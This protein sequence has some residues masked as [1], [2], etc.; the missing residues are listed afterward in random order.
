GLAVRQGVKGA[1]EK[2]VAEAVKAAV[3]RGAQ[4]GLAT[5]TIPQSAGEIYN[6]VAGEENGASIALVAGTFA[7]LLDIIPEGYVLG[8]FFRPGSV[9]RDAER[10]AVSRYLKALGTEAAKTMPM[11]GTTEAAQEFVNIA[12]AKFARG[13][14]PT[15]TDSDVERLANAGIIGSIGGAMFAPVAAAGEVRGQR[16]MPPTQPTVPLTAQPV[17]TEEQ[18]IQ[19]ASETFRREADQPLDTAERAD[20][21]ENNSPTGSAIDEFLAT[22]FGGYVAP[23]DRGVVREMPDIE[24]TEAPA[25]LDYVAKVQQAVAAA[26]E[27]VRNSEIVE[28]FAAEQEAIRIQQVARGMMGDVPR[29]AVAPDPL[30]GLG[31][32]AEPFEEPT[33]FDVYRRDQSPPA[34]ARA[35]P[36]FREIGAAVAAV[37]AAPD[38]V[39]APEPSAM[40]VPVATPDESLGNAIEIE[41]FRDNVY[42]A[43]DARIRRMMEDGKARRTDE[44]G[45]DV[46][47]KRQRAVL[48]VDR[49]TGNLYQRGIV[50]KND[51]RI[52]EFAQKRAAPGHGKGRGR[53]LT[54]DFDSPEGGLSLSSLLNETLD[55][56]SPRFEVAGF[57]VLPPKAARNLNLG[58]A[59]AYFQAPRFAELKEKRNLRK[60]AAET[61]GER[62]R[63]A[64]GVGT[65]RRKGGNKKTVSISTEAGQDTD[66]DSAVVSM[67]H[68]DLAAV[69]AGVVTPASSTG[70]FD[71]FVADIAEAFAAGDSPQKVRRRVSD[72]LVRRGIPKSEIERMTDWVI[73]K[74]VEQYGDVDHT[75]RARS[76][77]SYMLP[78]SRI[79]GLFQ[80]VV[81]AVRAHGGDVALFEQQAASQLAAVRDGYGIQMTDAEGRSLIAVATDSILNPANMDSLVRLVH[82]AAHQFIK[83]IP[84]SQ[85]RAFHQ[86]LSQLP[87][88]QQRWLMNPLSLDIR[89]LANA[90]RDQLSPVQLAALGKLTPEELNRLRA[91]SPET[92]LV[93]Q[94]AEHLAMLGVDKAQAR[95]IFSKALRLIKDVLLR[96]GMA[97]QQALGRSPSEQL[98][99]RYVEN[100]FLQFI[101]RDF[102]QG[103]QAV[104]AFRN[105]I[106]APATLVERIPIYQ[107]LG[108]GD[109]RVMQFDPQTG[110]LTPAEFVSDDTDSLLDALTALMRKAEMG[111]ADTTRRVSFS[112]INYT[113]EVGF[114]REAAV[115]NYLSEL[116]RSI[117]E[118]AGIRPVLPQEVRDAANPLG[119]FTQTYLGLKQSQWPDAKMAVLR[120]FVA[121]QKDPTTGKP[122][123][124]DERSTLA[125]LPTVK[126]EQRGPDGAIRL[127]ETSSAQDYAMRSVLAQ[128]YSAVDRVGGRVEQ[129]SEFV[130]RAKKR[131]S[132]SAEDR[133]KVDQLEQGVVIRKRVLARLRAAAAD[134]EIKTKSSVQQRFY[135]GAPYVVPTSDTSGEGSVSEHAL[136]LNLS[137]T[138][139]L[140]QSFLGHLRRMERW[141][142]NQDNLQHGAFYVRI[143]EQFK[144]L[145]EDYTT[146]YTYA[147]TNVLMRKTWTR[148]MVDTLRVINTP[149][150]LTSARRLVTL[151]SWIDRFQADSRIE[152][153]KW[154]AAF[155]AFAESLGRKPDEAF[156]EQVWDAF[157]RTFEQLNEADPKAKDKAAQV[158]TSVYGINVSPVNKKVWSAYLDLVNRTREAQA[159][160]REMHEAMGLRVEDPSLA[161][162]GETT[163]RRLLR[164]G[165]MNGRRGVSRLVSSLYIRM[166]PVWTAES[167]ASLSDPGSV[168]AMSEPQL[169]GAL[170]SLFTESVIR[171]FVEP[172]ARNNSPFI[173]LRDEYGVVTS[174]TPYDVRMAWERSDGNV[175]AFMR[176]LH[177]AVAPDGTEVHQTI[178]DVMRGF[179]TMFEQLKRD[180]EARQQAQQSG[181]E[182]GPRQ[183]M[184]ARLADNWPPEWVS[185]AKYDSTS[186]YVFMHQAAI[187][188]AVGRGG[189]GPG[190]EFMQLVQATLN[191]VRTLEERAAEL[192]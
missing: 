29:V 134:L 108:A 191:D 141:L 83:A 8:K 171:D 68:R 130:A 106:G 178:A 72:E 151:Q 81:Q 27:A 60:L 79:S 10:S 91:I 88:G 54:V 61:K 146:R 158:L 69:P 137:F 113:P 127:V 147:K 169:T 99:R 70:A 71:S 121:Q 167:L 163:E 153:G 4:A 51:K 85:H 82:E 135:P 112:S 92:L 73:S 12:A 36:D 104:T 1:A 14:P 148:S 65:V 125:S 58:N 52:V 86:A 145:T 186:N 174:V 30:S 33:P 22:S 9:V 109:P 98:V 63:E 77:Q 44:R 15:L 93:E 35:A 180:H 40:T 123:R 94:G 129:D 110:Q 26:A 74:T 162:D 28:G 156:E 57:V 31:Q 188:A 157:V 116:Q 47:D 102:A 45:K 155:Q 143:H 173:S 100:R 107:G 20:S 118:D 154:S 172:L 192:R 38:V 184:D 13:E 39:A 115:I 111:M 159:F 161:K 18:A 80:S 53:V 89:L 78:Q 16:E 189:F 97:L 25:E 105:W 84:A 96:A 138:P 11:E 7:G 103:P 46:D 132:L 67:D 62:I 136:P 3:K 24:T 76:P 182:T 131:T 144:R 90:P 49:A 55:E 185:Y 190:G 56:G 6:E 101:N 166:N 177:E 23:Q 126:E 133:L 59:T 66:I 19:L 87:W 142:Q 120:D 149:A 124:F 2:V 50:W 17:V 117:F 64:A 43:G 114:N 168:R 37:A 42:Q 187:H 152:G 75:V 150:A 175:L 122:A 165:Y 21:A 34:V 139:Q 128:L 179:G 119:A 95:D 181:M 164:L 183:M 160:E 140:E 170:S 176:A 41:D 48:L 5:A 32:A